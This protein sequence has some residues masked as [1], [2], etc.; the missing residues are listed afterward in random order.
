METELGSF[1]CDPD[2]RRKKA[3]ILS[4]Q[5]VKSIVKA[6]FFFVPPKREKVNGGEPN[7]LSHPGTRCLGCC[8]RAESVVFGIMVIFSTM[9]RDKTSS[10]FLPELSGKQDGEQML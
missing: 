5:F 1:Q 7:V 9:D 3:D 6:L 10:N 2:F 4:M 8:R